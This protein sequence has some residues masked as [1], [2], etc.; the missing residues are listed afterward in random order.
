[1]FNFGIRF[2]HLLLTPS[3]RKE[4]SDLS[5]RQ[6]ILQQHGDEKIEKIGEKQQFDVESG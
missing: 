1:M 6:E 3:S 2:L 4:P 5:S